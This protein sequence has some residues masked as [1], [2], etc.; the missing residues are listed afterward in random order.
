M[1]VAAVRH[2][3]D[4]A[5]VAILAY[6]FLLGLVRLVND[7]EWRHVALHQV[8]FTLA[9]AWLII[10]VGELIP[11]VDADADFGLNIMM[12]CSVATLSAAVFVALV[13]PRD[14]MP[15]SLNLDFS[16]K[17]GAQK[18]SPEETCSWLEYYVTY[19]W[20]TPLLWK[21]ARRQMTMEELPTLPWYDEPLLLL[22]RIQD[23]RRRSSSTVGTLFRFLYKELFAMTIYGTL[24][25]TIEL[26]AP[27]ALF[28]LLQ[29]IESPS[30]ATIRPWVWVILLF[31]GPLT[32]SITFQQYIFTSTR[33]IVRV[34]SAMT[35]E[36][37]YKAMGSMELDD[38][39]FQA[40]SSIGKGKPEEKKSQA[41]ATGRLA[42]MMSADI[43][44]ITSGRDVMLI[45]V[46]IPIGTMV[47]LVGM[48]KLLDWPALVGIAMMGVLSP[49]GV[50]LAQRMV[51]LQRKERQIQDSRI[52]AITEYLTSIRAVKYFA[53]ENAVVKR[54]SQIRLGEQNLIWNVNMK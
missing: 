26:V 11:A 51:T 47:A 50:V 37:Y 8:N 40:M 7:I 35:Q 24:A 48:Y 3:A 23:A 4:W 49:V 29:Y 46:G 19:E 38:D 30:T 53:W 36:L 44:A 32:R 6:A 14:W 52:S 25:F 27:Y 16:E 13:T 1:I 54:I 28:R 20:L 21:G 10:V 17:T 9:G 41:T 12:I 2:G 43:D 5:N 42:N 22:A 31:V 15:P 18:P 45:F 34:K 39:V 33:L